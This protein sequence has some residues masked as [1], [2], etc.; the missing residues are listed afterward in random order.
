MQCREFLQA[1]A[2]VVGAAAGD[3]PAAE[4]TAPTEPATEVDRQRRGGAVGLRGSA[5]APTHPLKAGERRIDA[6][7]EVPSGTVETYRV[8]YGGVPFGFEVSTDATGFVRTRMKISAEQAEVLA[9]D[10]L[11]QVRAVGRK[12]R[13]DRA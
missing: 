6:L 2:E 10:L 1:A 12:Q 11:E 5:Q 3:V 4:M 7:Y 8:D 9:V 13:V